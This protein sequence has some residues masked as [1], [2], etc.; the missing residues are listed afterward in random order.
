M[1]VWDTWPGAGP[2][3]EPEAEGFRDEQIE[4]EAARKEQEAADAAQASKDLKDFYS[5][6]P[7]PPPDPPVTRSKAKADDSKASTSH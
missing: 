7:E 3:P 2:A 1:S 5:G 6:T 4:A